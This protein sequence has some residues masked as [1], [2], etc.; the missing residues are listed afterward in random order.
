MASVKLFLREYHKQEQS[1]TIIERTVEIPAVPLNGQS[2][3]VTVNGRLRSFMV[4]GTYIPADGTPTI[5]AFVFAMAV[6]APYQ[7]AVRVGIEGDDLMLPSH[8]AFEGGTVKDLMA[9]LNGFP[10]DMVVRFN[11]DRVLDAKAKGELL[12]LRLGDRNEY[13]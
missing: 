12:V 13:Q 4:T 7:E 9:F 6:S 3:L 1:E 8:T 10:P 2:I 11:D 5:A